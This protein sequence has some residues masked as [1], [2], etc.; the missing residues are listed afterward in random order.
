MQTV[1]KSVP[2]LKQ[3]DIVHMHGG[4]FEVQEN[5]HAAGENHPVEGVYIASSICKSGKVAGYFHEGSAWVF[6]G[7]QHAIFCVEV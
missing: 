5:A 6:Q 4:T 2:E 3:G 7:N 1:N